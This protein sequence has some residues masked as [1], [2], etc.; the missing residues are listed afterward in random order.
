MLTRTYFV[1]ITFDGVPHFGIGSK[2]WKAASTRFARFCSFYYGRGH[3][4]KPPRATLF[5]VD[6][7]QPIKE[8]EHAKPLIENNVNPFSLFPPLFSI[9]LIPYI[10]TF[11]NFTFIHV[12]KFEY[13]EVYDKV[14]WTFEDTRVFCEI[15]IQEINANNRANGIMTTCDYNNITKKYKTV[16]GLHHSKA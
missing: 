15:Y 11:L 4:S 7:S 16:M 14:A 8:K 2:R 1:D 5:D 6:E 3:E 13:N 12:L 9:N 10:L